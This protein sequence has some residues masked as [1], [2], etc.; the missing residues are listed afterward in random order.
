MDQSLVIQQFQMIC[1]HL[2]STVIVNYLQEMLHLA[3]LVSANFLLHFFPSFFSLRLL[4]GGV[5]LVCERVL[6]FGGGLLKKIY[7]PTEQNFFKGDKL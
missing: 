2:S 3:M 6:F 1:A 4:L 5:F 7:V